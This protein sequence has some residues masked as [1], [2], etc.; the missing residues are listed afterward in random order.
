MSRIII[1]YEDAEAL[2]IDKPGGL[3]IE[4]PR[5]GGPSLED[6]LDELKP[7]IVFNALHGN[8][9]EDGTVQG[10]LELMGI[11]YTH[12]GVTTSAIAIDKELTKLLLVPAGVRMPRGTMVK[13]QALH[14]REPCSRGLNSA[15]AP[16][17]SWRTRS[18]IAT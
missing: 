7:D 17:R 6:R 5:K 14:E 1:L 2:V 15:R 4:R 3:P 16:G 10:M 18:R 8:P 12:S 13:S 9:G 11:P